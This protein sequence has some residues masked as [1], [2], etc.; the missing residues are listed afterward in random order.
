MTV[1]S[2]STFS[3]N[4][5]YL[6]NYGVSS[7]SQHIKQVFNNEWYRA[8]QR[9]TG[10]KTPLTL[11]QAYLEPS[12]DDYQCPAPKRSYKIKVRVISRT[13]G[14]PVSYNE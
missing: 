9:Q 8:V 6:I 12:S 7:E 3:N 1:T 13:K 14:Q 5:P 4:I 2:S 10:A 11:T